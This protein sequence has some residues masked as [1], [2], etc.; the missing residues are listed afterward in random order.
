M[1]RQQGF[2]LIG[3]LLGIVIL[4]LIGWGAFT[5]YTGNSEKA[6]KDGEHAGQQAEDLTEDNVERNDALE[7]ATELEDEQE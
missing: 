6:V 2:G 5:L 7:R 3:L 1:H 4:G